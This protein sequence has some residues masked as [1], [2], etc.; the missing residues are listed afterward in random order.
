MIDLALA[1]KGIGS[2]PAGTAFAA[3]QST[4][5]PVAQTVASRLGDVAMKTVQAVRNEV[6]GSG[7]ITTEKVTGAVAKYGVNAVKLALGGK[8][9]GNFMK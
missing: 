8:I 9:F 1:T 7:P 4:S 6:L 2:I 5:L 3:D